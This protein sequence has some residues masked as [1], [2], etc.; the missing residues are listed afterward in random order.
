MVIVSLVGFLNRRVDL[1]GS[2]VLVA[3]VGRAGLVGRLCSV[4]EKNGS[5]PSY[6][7]GL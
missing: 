5:L 1:T 3:R 7:V 6:N 2:V 4:E